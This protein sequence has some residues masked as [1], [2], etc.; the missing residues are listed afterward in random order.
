MAEVESTDTDL[1]LASASPRR[2][3]LMR[4]AGYT[5]KI[6]TPPLS[7][8]DEM[9]SDVP[10]EAQA[11]AWSY[12]KARSVGKT[13]ESGWII[14]A[15]TIVAL[16]G[17]VY[18]KPADVDDARRI[19]KT[20]AGTRHRVITGLTL[21]DAHTGNRLISHDITTV[22]MRPLSGEALDQYLAGEGWVGKAGAYGIQDKGDAF[23]ERL[24]GSFTNVVGLPMELLSSLL[25]RWGYP[26]AP[27]PAI[28]PESL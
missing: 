21:L 20:L 26:H 11:E 18:G 16:G 15:D 6:I 1:I 8:P 4:Q 22:T 27:D 9:G 25:Q 5:F 14:G 17:H 7:E 2:A 19:L 10:A 13:V 24:D 23:I 3:Q 12:F 28:A